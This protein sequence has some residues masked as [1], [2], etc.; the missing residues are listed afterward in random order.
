MNKIILAVISVTILAACSQPVKQVSSLKVVGTQLTDTNGTPVMLRGTSYG[1]HNWWPRFYN[2]P[3]LN[4]MVTDW[5]INVVRAAMGVE[6]DSG[7]IKKPVWS[8][9][10]VSVIVDAA[11][12][13]N[14]YVLI[15]WHSHGL[16][17]P[18]AVEFFTKM[19][20]KYG[21]YPNVI[22]EIYNEPDYQ[23]WDTV[24]HYSIE[25]IK[26]IRK[27][28]PDNVILV[29]CPHW[30]QDIHIVADDPITG[31]DNIM[32]TVHFY[33][34][35]HQQWLR[36]RCDYALSKGIPIFVSESAGMFANGDGA[37]DKIEWQAWIDY[38]ED[39]KISWIVWSIADKYESCSML[40]PEASSEGNWKESDLK[41]SG[42]LTREYIRKY[43]GLPK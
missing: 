1:W 19:A 20:Q 34:A 28:D 25:V 15:D 32:Y 29:G 33:A 30:D 21:Q 35:T 37:I 5:G 10:L 43:N 4:W 23:S 13:N 39:K 3:S 41:E 24:K 42:L 7:Y 22:Y 27:Y 18:E 12:K 26:A 14:I 31:F 9:S 17:T 8:D 38:M 2:E 16:F 36:D 40:Q 11:I 6:P